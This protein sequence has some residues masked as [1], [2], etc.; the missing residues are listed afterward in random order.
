M[1]I[2]GVAFERELGKT[3]RRRIHSVAAD[4]GDFGSA[5][6]FGSGERRCKRCGDSCAGD[7]IAERRGERAAKAIL[8]FGDKRVSGG[9]DK[10]RAAAGQ[11]G[12]G[13][14]RVCRVADADAGGGTKD[15]GR[16]GRNLR[17]SAAT[18]TAGTI[19]SLA[20]WVATGAHSVVAGADGAGS[21]SC[22]DGDQVLE[23]EKQRSNE[24]GT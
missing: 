6:N 21:D 14:E 16:F 3:T 20:A 8:S 13:E 17:R 9:A 18:G 4:C 12:E 11:R 7:F 10:T 23:V 22:G 2:A 15:G 24:V 19:A 1:R 5:E